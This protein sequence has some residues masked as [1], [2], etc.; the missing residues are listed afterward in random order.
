MLLKF[1][2]FSNYLRRINPF[3][4]SISAKLLI[5]IFLAATIPMSL[6]AHNNLKLSLQNLAQSE[7]DKLE[8]I[9]VSNATRLDQL[10]LGNRLIV[11]Q[12]ARNT[13]IV[14][15][16]AVNSVIKEE[17]FSKV[18]KSLDVILRSSSD[19]DAV[20]IIDKN[21]I[22]RASTNPTFIGQS[23]SSQDYFKKA[24]QSK[25]AA[26]VSFSVEAASGRPELFF[27][28]P[29]RSERG[30]T[31]GVAVLEIQGS[32]VWKAM[33]SIR[34]DSH[35]GAFL[36]D[37]R[38]VVIAHPNTSYLYRS[39][40]KLP[41]NTQKELGAN[42][43]YGREKIDSLELPEL[44]EA[45]VGTKQIGHV[46][47]YSPIEK[48]HQIAGFA[49]LQTKSWVLGVNKPK[50]IFEA[51][52]RAMIWQNTLFV[53]MVGGFAV[54]VSLLLSHQLIKSIRTLI[55]AGKALQ[56]GEFKPELLI[57][58]SRSPDD[59][60]RL[61]CVFLQMAEEIKIREQHLKSQVQNLRVEIDETKKE[62]QISEIT[63]T[64]YFRGLQKKAQRL[65]NRAK[66]KEQ[67]ESAYFQNLQK[68]V[69]DQ[70]NR[71]VTS[72]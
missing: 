38:G 45:I 67:T 34:V 1:A 39:L 15:F 59:L 18:E 2:N 50:D 68:K 69:K 54:L 12:I 6:T 31:L 24:I 16:L 61:A 58:V 3:Y 13:D 32:D 40:N 48:T 33:N 26:S 11:N 17:L 55:K 36:V 43:S 28:H 21:G 65:K 4:W 44:A 29:I 42:N 25:A 7:F 64:E 27:A 22:C 63:K 10:I 8:V 23:Q 30:E 35:V 52:M 60:G 53:L 37:E 14:K 41:P 51:P 5:V 9:A 47:Y 71:F 46:S 20:F 57:K 49:P 66:T 62:R 56:R 19:Y 72:R 70:K